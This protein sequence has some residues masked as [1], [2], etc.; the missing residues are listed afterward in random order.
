MVD[1][2]GQ[3]RPLLVQVQRLPLRPQLLE[4]RPP[5]PSPWGTRADTGDLG[6]QVGQAGL[7]SL[8]LAQVLASVQG[9]IGQVVGQPLQPVLL[10]LPLGHQP[11]QRRP[12]LRCPL[13]GPQ[14]PL[15]E[16][17]QQVPHHMAFQGFSDPQQAT[18]A[19]L[20]V[21]HQ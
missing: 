14:K 21:S 10:G 12:L 19:P 6:I 5:Q 20:R 3:D 9:A 17:R 2:I 8:L 11:A 16:P 15:R 4:G 7:Q 1:M 13:G 18:T